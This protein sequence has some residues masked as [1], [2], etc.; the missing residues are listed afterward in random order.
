MELVVFLKQVLD[1]TRFA[2]DGQGNPRPDVPTMLNPLD[3]Y[4]L[5]LALR[6]KETHALN[7][8]VTVVSAGSPSVKDILKKAIAAGADQAVFVHDEAITARDGLSR[9]KILK[10]TITTLTNRGI[11][12]TE[13]P[14]LYGFGQQ[15]LDT[16]AGETGPAFAALMG[17]ASY[18]QV[19]SASNLASETTSSL[20]VCCQESSGSENH[21][22]TLPAVLCTIKGEHELRTAN[23]K[24]VMR[25]NK[26]EIS[27]LT[28]ADIGLEGHLNGLSPAGVADRAAKPAG[29][30]IQPASPNEAADAIV[31]YL[32]SLQVV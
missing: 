10:A 29:R 4:A 11:L 3:E 24:G 12:S 30:T 23:I 18:T 31:S 19:K 9:A 13:A 32:S 6:L 21:V 25:A 1:N 28:L 20:A 26:T 15:A 5:E 7:P 22:I 8:R 14:S 17:I 16:G 27:T 2:T